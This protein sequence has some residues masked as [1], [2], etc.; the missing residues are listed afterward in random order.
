MRLKLIEVNNV[1]NIE[2]KP[3]S[4]WRSRKDKKA[5]CPSL[6][7]PIIASLTDSDIEVSILDEKNEV[8]DFNMEV[9]VVG[10]SFKSMT[11]KRAYEIADKFRAKGVK[12]IMGGVH[13]SLLPDEAVK[14]ADSVVV[15][16]A[17]NTWQM[18][19]KDIKAN[20]LKRFYSSLEKVDLKTVPLPRFDLL[21]N[22]KYLHHAI[23]SSRGC[24]LGCEFCPTRFMFGWE[25]RLKD[26]SQ[27]VQ[28]IQIV[29]GIKKKGIFFVD[30]VFG[31]GKKDYIIE[32][33]KRL[34][35]FMI[36]FSIISDFKV[37]NDVE[38]LESLAGSGC[39]I[40]SLNI[41]NCTKEEEQVIKKIHSYGI[42]TWGYFMFGFE[43]H[44]ETIFEKCLK[45]INETNM[46]YFTLTVLSPYPNTPLYQQFEREGRILSKDWSLYDQAHVVFKPKLMFPEALE[47][48]YRRVL[49][50][51]MPL[52]EKEV[53]G[54]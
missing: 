14:H 11:A 40:I 38:L 18:V 33:T 6:A 20:R 28:E 51:T 16:E 15:G 44:D 5:A 46:K 35:S 42:E 34:K 50:E 9:N 27:V 45:F 25:F 2:S 12:I 26:V 48:G 3:Y 41:A 39:K 17:E 4:E 8:I 36:N 54:W 23:Q 31:A 7:L 49:D 30:D 13:A 37:I 1:N 52:L 53:M 22:D 47:N 43:N 21:Q 10:I 29:Q 19:I 24:S 32:L